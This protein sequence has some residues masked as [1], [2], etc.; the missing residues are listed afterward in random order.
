MDLNHLF[1]DGVRR[2]IYVI[3]VTKAQDSQNAAERR[4]ASED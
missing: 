1:Q 3:I 2:R 4:P